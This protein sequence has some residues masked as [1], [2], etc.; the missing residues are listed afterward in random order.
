M[1]S[2]QKIFIFILNSFSTANKIHMQNFVKRA[3]QKWLL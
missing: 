3:I 2:Y 1:H